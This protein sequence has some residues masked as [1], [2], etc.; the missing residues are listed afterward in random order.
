MHSSGMR[1]VRC[2][3]RFR[4]GMFAEEVGVLPGGVYLG[5][6]C[7][8]GGLPRGCTPPAVDRQKDACENIPF[9]NSSC[10]R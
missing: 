5:G 9:R 10:G 7:P 6:V 3:G 2:S 8:E 4:G 1:T